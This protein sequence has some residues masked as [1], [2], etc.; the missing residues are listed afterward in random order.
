MSDD[1]FGPNYSRI[2]EDPVTLREQ[3]EIHRDNLYRE[4]DGNAAARY[5][6]WYEEWPYCS[7]P[8]AFAI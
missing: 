3:V 6:L 7:I 4:S 5:R 2:L 8:I 1:E